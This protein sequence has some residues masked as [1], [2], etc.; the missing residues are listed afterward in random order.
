MLAK[1]HIEGNVPEPHDIQK[2]LVR[3]V[4]K[5]LESRYQQ[6]FKV[7]CELLRDGPTQS[8]AA[9][10][11]YYAWVFARGSNGE[12]KELE[13]AARLA[14][15]NKTHFEVT[16]FLAAEEVQARPDDVATV[17]PQALIND[18]VSRSH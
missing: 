7:R 9:Y 8:G 6:S 14:A 10:P 18:I 17:F 5:Y 15:V 16:D 3:D 2:F 12:R 4:T 13:G 11:K 1:S